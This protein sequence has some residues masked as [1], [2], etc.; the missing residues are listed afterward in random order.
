MKDFVLVATGAAVA[1]L[2]ILT[3]PPL[4]EGSPVPV[5]AVSASV[6]FTTGWERISN[7]CRSVRVDL[8]RPDEPV[9]IAWTHAR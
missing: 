1:A 8:E 7:D 4:L 6:T 2:C 9:C 3:L 5:R